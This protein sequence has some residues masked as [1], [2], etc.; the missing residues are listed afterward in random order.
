M[1]YLQC[2]TN[3][4]EELIGRNV[5]V[6]KKTA[7]PVTNFGIKKRKKRERKASVSDRIRFANVGDHLP[8][9]TS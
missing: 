4:A 2:L 6:K 9:R 5:S 8:I 3:T 7:R 1:R